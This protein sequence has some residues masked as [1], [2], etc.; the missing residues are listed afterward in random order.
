MSSSL[1]FSPGCPN[2]FGSFD[3]VVEVDEVYV[4]AGF[5]GRRR[6]R[7]RYEGDK[8]PIMVMVSRYGGEDYIPMSSMEGCF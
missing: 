5:K 6:G 2:S 7:G 8:I 3:G 1:G 4:S